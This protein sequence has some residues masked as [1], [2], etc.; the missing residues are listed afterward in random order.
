MHMKYTKN[1][2]SSHTLSFFYLTNSFNLLKFWKY[3]FTYCKFLHFSDN[4]Y[5]SV[6][7]FVIL[8]L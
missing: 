4:I 3:S 8:L 2:D 5:N 6:Q 7:V 1:E